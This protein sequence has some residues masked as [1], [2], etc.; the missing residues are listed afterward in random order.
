VPCEFFCFLLLD[1][2]N[3]SRAM[4]AASASPLARNACSSLTFSSLARIMKIALKRF[5]I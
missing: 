2:E 3:F 4:E 5:G 1:E